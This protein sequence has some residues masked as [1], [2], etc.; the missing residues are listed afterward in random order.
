MDWVESRFRMRFFTTACP[1]C[2]PT[3][4]AR[5]NSSVDYVHACVNHG[6][7]VIGRAR[8]SRRQR[9]RLKHWKHVD[10]FFQPLGSREHGR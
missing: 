4:K 10:L 5:F 3:A 7:D 2:R 8:T 9:K 1:G 6:L